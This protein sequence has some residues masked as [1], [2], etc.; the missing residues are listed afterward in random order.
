M[1]MK[2]AI[3]PAAALLAACSM[4]SSDTTTAT[5]AASAAP[6]ATHYRVVRHIPIGGEGGWDYLTVDAA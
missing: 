4:H 5:P 3:L 2:F 6:A 1:M